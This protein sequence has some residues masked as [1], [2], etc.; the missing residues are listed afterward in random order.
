MRPI[1]LI[2]DVS[3]LIA[4]AEVD[5][6]LAV[7]EAIAMLGEDDVAAAI[8]ASAL[9]SAYAAVGQPDE[10]A[11]LERLVV[12]RAC[13]LLAL[14]PSDA[15]HIGALCGDVGLQIGDAQAVQESMHREESQLATFE[16]EQYRA[17]SWLPA[18]RVFPLGLDWDDEPPLTS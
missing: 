11:R 6:G 13:P 3:A 4:Y 1:R 18:D 9:A 16:P 10:R 15:L 5:R 17:V 8:P 7:A 12:A 2:F 14:E